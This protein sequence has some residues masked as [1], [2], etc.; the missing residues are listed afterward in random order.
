MK[1]GDSLD[2]F[3]ILKQIGSGGMA[4]VYIGFDQMT[5]ELVAIKVLY[6]Q[7]AADELL[8]KRFQRE[9]AILRGL[10]HPNIVKLVDA[11]VDGDVHYMSLEYVRGKSLSE[12]LQARRKLPVDAALKLV[13]DVARALSHAHA[14]SIVHRDVKP[15]NIMVIDPPWSAKI[16]D[17]GV[18]QA[19]DQLLQSMVGQMLGTV[20]YAAP[21][22]ILGRRVDERADIYSMGLVCYEMLT[23]V[24]PFRNM[25]YF[26]IA[27]QQLI[28]ALGA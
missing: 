9:V 6:K 12:I 20:T 18:A 14:S 22:Q 25:D 4:S 2:R 26:A 13:K 19:D 1:F 16:L 7:I 27:H 21:E 10:D 24:N 17:F 15:A 28:D 11:G 3:G 23:G 5:C 8:L